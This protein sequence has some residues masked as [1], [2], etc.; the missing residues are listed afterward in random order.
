MFQELL[1]RHPVISFIKTRLQEAS[2]DPYVRKG[3][4]AL[5]GLSSDLFHAVQCASSRSKGEMGTPLMKKTSR[6]K[7][8]N[9]MERSPVVSSITTRRDNETVRDCEGEEVEKKE[10]QV[11]RNFFVRVCVV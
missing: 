11:K 9:S 4:S 2:R 7:I 6:L 10:S 1:V 3:R 5:E 8:V